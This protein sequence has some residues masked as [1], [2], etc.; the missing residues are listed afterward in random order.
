MA[1]R[2]FDNLFTKPRPHILEEICLSLDYN[3][4]KNCV[5][6]NK[7]W[8]TVLKATYFQKKAKSVFRAE[9]LQDE[10]KLCEIS[11][12][13]NTEGV[14]KLLSVGLL[15]VDCVEKGGYT[16]LYFAAMGSHKDVVQ[17]LL[18]GGCQLRL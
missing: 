5:V 3:T 12:E 7:T 8:N 16:P 6:I 4:L 13:G 14:R 2:E 18:D 1:F 15:D 17:L 9:I 10:R 11:E